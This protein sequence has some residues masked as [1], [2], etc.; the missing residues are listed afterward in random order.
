MKKTISINLK[1]IHF[2]I[3]EDAYE[4]LQAYLRRL[5][6]TLGNTEGKQE[7]IDDIEMRIAELF[8]EKLDESG[9]QV[10]EMTDV[11][12]TLVTLGEP[13]EFID[14]EERGSN[15][16]QSEFVDEG[17]SRKK[18]FR[19]LENA[20]IAGV[21]AGLANYFSMDVMIVR[22]I[23][24]FI[25]LFGGF[26]IPLYIVLWIVIPK[27]N[28]NIDRLRMRGIPVTVENVR[29]EVEKAAQR[30]SNSSKKFARKVERES[31]WQDRFYTLGRVFSTLFGVFAIF[32]AIAITIA[33]AVLI[34]GQV[35]VMPINGDEGL[36][37]LLE[38]TRLF[39]ADS[40]DVTLMWWT[41]SIV[42]ITSIIFLVTAGIKAVFNL[43]MPWF[44][45]LSRANL[46]I[47]IAAVTMC[48][49]FGTIIG[50]EY[51]MEST[52]EKSIG[53]VS[54]SLNFDIQYQRLPSE[55]AEV[56]N[57]HPF[58]LAVQ[59]GQIID[60]SLRI[61]TIRSKDSNFHIRTI[62]QSRGQSQSTAMQNARRIDFKPEIKGNT[63]VV[64]SEFSYP[65]GDKIRGQEA[66]ILIEI[67][68][69]KEINYLDEE[70]HYRNSRHGEDYDEF[71]FE[72]EDFYF[73]GHTRYRHHRNHRYNNYNYNW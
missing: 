60:E 34:I 41:G 67:P 48:F 26:A 3:E 53:S 22:L 57:N 1:G 43:K 14:E 38:F 28:S 65:I 58:W 19:D 64:P 18:L 33:Y 6:Q 45:Y 46:L 37:S 24:I 20:N 55:N 72:V 4:T 5:E 12:S 51:T 52:I 11:E 23:F 49:Y 54:D 56:N 69:G 17:K 8:S 27:V 29:E 9:K 62:F 21:C 13:E 7:I 70:L 73:G 40:G 42:T 71:D 30:M 15:E 59:N 50:R 63:L 44:K 31:H 32:L 66:F 36:Y 10:V 16:T 39:V 2:I 35:G 61:R 25:V 68:L 47:T